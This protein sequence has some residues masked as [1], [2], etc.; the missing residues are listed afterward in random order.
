MCIHKPTIVCAACPPGQ[1]Y[2][3]CEISGCLSSFADRIVIFQSGQEAR[4][5]AECAYRLVMT[6]QVK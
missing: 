5:C 6:G 3:G 1:A 2:P 4:V